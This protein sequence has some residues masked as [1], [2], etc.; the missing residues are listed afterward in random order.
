MRRLLLSHMPLRSGLL[1]VCVTLAV[2]ALHAQATPAKPA[3]ASQSGAFDAVAI[4]PAAPWATGASR[5]LAVD[6]YSAINM[7]IA[8]TVST[9][10]FAPGLPVRDLLQGLP[11]WASAERYD[12]TAKV[13]GATATQW[14][15]LTPAQLHERAMP[16]LQ[17]LLA[18][19]FKLVYHRVP[20]EI[21]GFALVVSKGGA[22]LEVAPPDEAAPARPSIP[23]AEGGWIV[24]YSR[25]ENPHMTMR[26]V[27]IGQLVR[28]L[29][30][31]VIILDQTGLTGRYNIALPL[32][33]P[34]QEGIDTEASAFERAH[35][36][37]VT[38]VGLELKPIKI[39]TEKI[40][41]DSMERPSAN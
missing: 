1:A 40:V 28:N 11:S 7:P 13:D 4:R 10:F 38:L 15:G 9:A 36:W 33:D 22:R 14:K 26:N 16:L 29:S 35:Y 20:A 5:R 25:G 27:T 8:T 30:M 24:P 2:P 18:D 12:I 6:T 3:D 41:I 37:D 31:G 23:Q 17:G 39:P 19:R 34:S 21:Q 32:T